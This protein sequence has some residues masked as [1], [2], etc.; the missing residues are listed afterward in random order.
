MMVMVAKFE[1]YAKRLVLLIY[2]KRKLI[3]LGTKNDRFDAI[4]DSKFTEIL[5]VFPC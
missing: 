4:Q 1:L 3:H 2:I 5:M